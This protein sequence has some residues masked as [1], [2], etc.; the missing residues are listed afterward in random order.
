MRA[1]FEGEGKRYDVRRRP[2]HCLCL[3]T[4][5]PFFATFRILLL[6]IHGL[7]LISED[8]SIPKK[9]IEILYNQPFSVPESSYLGR[10][11][12]QFTDSSNVSR[13]ELPQLTHD[14]SLKLPHFSGSSRQDVPILPLLIILGV[15]R[16]MYLL[17][18]VLT[19]KRII[20]IAENVD[21]LSSTIHATIAMIYPFTWHHIF[22]PC[23]PSSLVMYAETPTPYLL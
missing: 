12:T 5:Q 14:Y 6:E 4:R 8:Q 9:F 7:A 20:F 13:D 22:I 10:L 21:T 1:L 2:R 18:A 17:N 3:I 19:E 11:K 16:L 23:L 15:D